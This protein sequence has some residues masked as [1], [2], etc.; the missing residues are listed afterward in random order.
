MCAGVTV[1]VTSHML[2]LCNAKTWRDFGPGYV[3]LCLQKREE[4]IEQREPQQ[5]LE[6]AVVW[7][8]SG[9]GLVSAEF[10]EY[11][12]LTGM[13][14]RCY[15]G[16]LRLTIWNVCWQTEEQPVVFIC[17]VKQPKSLCFNYLSQ[18]SKHRFAQSLAGLKSKQAH[19]HASFKGLLSAGRA[20][21][22]CSLGL[23]RSHINC[24]EFA[25]T[26]CVIT[27]TPT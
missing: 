13:L 24:E 23:K 4:K 9:F 12:V 27:P 2:L 20:F 1:S 22:E 15:L 11:Q 21:A 3:S 25:C 26:M 5:Q 16:C 6:R 10:L 17:S 18:S 7:V 8:I 14:S 19:R